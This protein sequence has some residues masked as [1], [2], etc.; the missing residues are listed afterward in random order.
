MSL[1]IGGSAW[2]MM[3]EAGGGVVTVL[4]NESLG[5]R[6]WDVTNC[7]KYADFEATAGSSHVIRF[8]DNGAVRID[9]ITGQALAKGPG[10]VGHPPTG[11]EVAPDS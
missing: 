8:L 7:R 1:E 4:T 10:L 6:L 3:P 9:D 5:V 11:C 2:S